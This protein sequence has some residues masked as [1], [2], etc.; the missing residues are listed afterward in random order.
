MNMT[1]SEG[2]RKRKISVLHLRMQRRGGGG[3]LDNVSPKNIV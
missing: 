2:I 3:N 1:T